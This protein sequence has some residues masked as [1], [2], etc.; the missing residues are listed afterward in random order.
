MPRYWVSRRRGNGVESF[1]VEPEE[2]RRARLEGWKQIAAHLG[3]DIRTVQRWERK[4]GLPVQ[5]HHH[6]VLGSVFADPDE[7]DSWLASR[8]R[9]SD[10]PDPEAPSENRAEPQGTAIEDARIPDGELSRDGIPALKR[11]RLPGSRLAVATAVAGFVFG[12][13]IFLIRL[14]P[15]RPGGEV[16]VLVGP[17]RNGTPEEALPEAARHL[18]ETALQSSTVVH[19]ASPERIAD[20][21]RLLGKRPDERLDLELARQVCIRDGG[22]PV[23]VT[24][25]IERSGSG[26]VLGARLLDPLRNRTIAT[27]TERAA[28]SRELREAVE[29]L[30]SWICRTLGEDPKARPASPS[31]SDGATTSSPRAAYLFAQATRIG[32]AGAWPVTEQLL[33]EAIVEDPEFALAHMWLAFAISNQRRP[34]EDYL[35]HAER[36]LALAH[37]ASDRERMFIRAGVHTLRGEVEQ[38]VPILEAM[39]G[40]YPQDQ[41]ALNNLGGNLIRTGEWNR[42]ADAAQRLLLARPHHAGT[43]SF[44]ARTL[45]TRGR[46]AD[47]PRIRVYARQS[48]RDTDIP[49][50]ESLEKAEWREGSV[51]SPWNRTTWLEDLDLFLLWVGREPQAVKNALDAAAAR[52][53]D[54]AGERGNVRA[55]YLGLFYLSIGRTQDA[56][57]LFARQTGRNMRALGKAWIA[58]LNDDKGAVREA[59]GAVDFTSDELTAVIAARCGLAPRAAQ[60]R[61]EAA[62]S[63]YSMPGELEIIDGEIAAAQGHTD[64]AAGLLRSGRQKLQETSSLLF[65]L[66]SEKLAEL[67]ERRGDSVTAFQILRECETGRTRTYDTFGPTSAFWLKIRSHTAAVAK[68]IGQSTEAEKIE[69]DIA[70]DLASADAGN[71]RR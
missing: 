30:S 53:L 22:I 58:Y 24:G 34:R 6:D 52:E 2:N 42:A 54:L 18:M 16:W 15:S 60:I 10:G 50:L 26:Y 4:E 36:A 61:Q 66:A 23:L 57:R 21:L 48:L 71:K 25:T 20:T 70:H 1:P 56:E 32:S 35:P 65:F 47:F 5:R 45:L 11:F 28:E 33:R 39:I 31:G 67:H 40:L 19:S 64:E 49:Y 62:A 51:R 46:D 63:R 29:R 17:F 38:A 44:A 27:G 69:Q 55:R 43:S 3:R 14:A 7:L 68:R 37:R 8:K 59:L 9:A 41:W 13:A 12:A